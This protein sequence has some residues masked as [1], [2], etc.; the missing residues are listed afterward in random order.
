M[1]K[2]QLS[3]MI[4]LFFMSS[5]SDLFSQK[6]IYEERP[7]LGSGLPE[8]EKIIFLDTLTGKRTAYDVFKNNPFNNL[9]F[10]RI[11]NTT[12][13][14]NVYKLSYK[15]VLRMIPEKYRALYCEDRRKIENNQSKFA[16]SS[17]TYLYK[18]SRKHVIIA[19]SLFLSQDFL[20]TIGVLGSIDVFTNL[21]VSIYKERANDVNI[22]NPVI[23]ENRKYLYYTYGA[24]DESGCLIDKGYR[25]IDMKTKKI[26]MDRRHE[27]IGGPFV[28]NNLIING[29]S[30]HEPEEKHVYIVIDSENQ[31]IYTKE[32]SLNEKYH[33]KEINDKG[34]LISDHEKNVDRFDSFEKC[35]SKEII[36]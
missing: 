31:I 29:Y 25:L 16:A 4:L 21:G 7:A 14:N 17:S 6:I 23:S 8:V 13:Y 32:Y 22:L 27:S 10:P 9:K 19:S 3:L 33:V 26:I 15:D 34:F 2:S 20:L 5:I 11:E 18:E 35:F 28:V 24:E 1:N 30:I 12:S 36:K